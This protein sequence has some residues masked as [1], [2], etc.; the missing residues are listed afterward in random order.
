MSRFNLFSPD[1]IQVTSNLQADQFIP[2]NVV[3]VMASQLADSA[4]EKI[5]SRVSEGKF[6]G[7]PDG[8]GPVRT[9][10]YSSGSRS[11]PLTRPN[12][13]SRTRKG[14]YESMMGRVQ[15]QAGQEG[16]GVSS[17][18]SSTGRPWVYVPGG[19]SRLRRIAGLP[20]GRVNLSFTGRLLEDLVVKPSIERFGESGVSAAAT[21]IGGVGNTVGGFKASGQHD[22]GLAD[23]IASIH[24]QIGFSTQS[25]WRIARWQAERYNHHFAL[26]T[27]GEKTELK[28]EG[29]RLA[30][31]ARSKYGQASPSFAPR[32]ESGQFIPIDL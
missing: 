15:A 1:E 13:K 24:I 31:R 28:Q 30:K 9:E 11:F 18:R 32:G 4:E 29:L 2:E 19:Y 26:L 25:S 22:F 27:P 12:E 8:T 21:Q 17:F 7:N 16:N 6:P 20:S 3:R 14:R 23:V 5:I 10:T